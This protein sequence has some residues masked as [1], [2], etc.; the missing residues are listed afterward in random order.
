M[1]QLNNFDLKQL[2]IAGLFIVFCCASTLYGN[3]QHEKQRTVRVEVISDGDSDKVLID[4]SFVH[5]VMV[6]KMDSDHLK[7]DLDSILKHHDKALHDEIKIMAFA[8]D[9]LHEFDMDVSGAE[10]M[11]EMHIEMERLLKEKG[12][13]LKEMEELHKCSPHHFYWYGEKDSSAQNINVETIVTDEGENI[14]VI[15][16]MIEVKG[17]DQDGEK[18]TK[19]YVICSTD[20]QPEMKFLE[21]S[22]SVN[23]ESI[24]ME[25][26]SIL[27]KAGVDDKVVFNTPIKVEKMKLMVRQELVNEVENLVLT[28]EMVL[29]EKGNYELKMIDKEGNMKEHDKKVKSGHVKKEYKLEKTQEP[30]YLMLLRN[31][32]IFGRKIEI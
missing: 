32:Q 15:T 22:T 19:K 6:F 10:G 14:K 25:D 30:Y 17:D 7:I 23:V 13:C 16:K 27:R 4:T 31:N 29:P 5:D 3:A 11:E 12:M 28:I 26:I 2:R 24:P 18:K 1:K 9:S 21:K 20:R 8:M